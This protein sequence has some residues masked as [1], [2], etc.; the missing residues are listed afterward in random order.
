MIQLGAGNAGNGW[1]EKKGAE[2]YIC[3]NMIMRLPS[4][5]D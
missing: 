1:H 4:G 2:T 5:Y 3:I